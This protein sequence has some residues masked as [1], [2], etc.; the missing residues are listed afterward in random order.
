MPFLRPRRIPVVVLAALTGTV[1]CDGESSPTDPGP[2]TGNLECEIQSYPCSLSEVDL[3]ILVRSDE[4]GDSVL[5]ML[6][7]GSSTADAAAWLAGQDGMADV[8]SGGLGVWFRL[9]GGR[10]TWVVTEGATLAEPGPSAAA[11]GPVTPSRASPHVQDPPFVGAEHSVVAQAAPDHRALPRP[12]ASRGSSM[13]LGAG[14]SLAE[15]IVSEIGSGPVTPSRVAPDFKPL[16]NI[17]GSGSVQKKALVLSSALWEFKSWDS[18]PAVR[19]ILASTRGYEYEGGVTFVSNAESTATDVGLASFMGWDAYDVVH[20]MSHGMRVCDDSQCRGMII[21]NELSTFFSEALSEGE[22]IEKLK[23]VNQPGVDAVKRSGKRYIAVNADFFWIHAADVVDTV[24]FLNSCQ[25]FGG[26]NTDLIDALTGTSNVVFGWTEAVWSDDAYYAATRLFEELSEG[27]Y[28]AAIA[29]ERLG[30]L[31]TGLSTEHGPSPTLRMAQRPEGG[32]L[33]IREVVTLLDPGSGQELTADDKVQI[34]GVP[35]DGEPDAAPFLV[36]VDGVVAEHASDMLLQVSV[37]GVASDPVQVSSGTANEQDQWIVEGQIPL[38][39]DLDDDR[40]VT[41]LARVELASEGESEHESGAILT[42][43]SWTL[44]SEG[45]MTGEVSLHG[46]DAQMAQTW[47]AEAQF[48][49]DGA[50]GVLGQGMGFLSGTEITL[51]FDDEQIYCLMSGPFELGFVFDLTGQLDDGV[52]SLEAENLEEAEFSATSCPEVD[53]AEIAA[54]YLLIMADMLETIVPF[55][56][57]ASREGHLPVSGPLAHDG[58]VVGSFEALFTWTNT[59][60][61]EGCPVGAGDGGC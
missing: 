36:Q 32:D 34:E 41:F 58:V 50:G 48:A 49:V 43:A 30:G 46:Q 12:A 35:G 8:M 47:T 33:Q 25:L 45:E 27:G 15:H 4:L 23:E 22:L 24:I 21:V 13:T 11:T 10:G 9:E 53:D 28:P 19:D 26:P 60:R 6:E 51:T 1:G 40:P 5:A 42:G 37:D 59:I 20:V 57:E 29:Y 54:T 38:D 2:P 55:E 44:G 56:H 17:V 16:S 14:V 3:P 52:L 31:R 39:Y 61:K 7:S 18:G